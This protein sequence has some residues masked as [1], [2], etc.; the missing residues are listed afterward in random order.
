MMLQ[1]RAAASAAR[2]FEMLDE[3]PTIVDRPGAIDLVDPTRR[4]RVPRCRLRL[5]GQRSPCSKALV[6]T[7]RRA[8]PWRSSGAPARGKCTIARLLTRFYDVDSGAVL[9]DGHDVR[10][11]TMP[12]LRH[13][14]GVVLDEPFLFS[15]SV[16]ANIAYGRP[17]A[18]V[19]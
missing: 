18:R 11:L 4:D 2:I 5:S 8:R 13:H 9:V 19:Q 3:K 1:Q 6:L 12:S 16:R 15:E 14:V 10:D 17:N 7:C